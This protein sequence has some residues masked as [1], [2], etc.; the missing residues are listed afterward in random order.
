MPL[1]KPNICVCTAALLALLH[2]SVLLITTEGAEA[3]GGVLS[4]TT[5]EDTVLVSAAYALELTTAINIT[6]M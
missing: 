2:T 6:A 1:A 5:V 3:V 4:V